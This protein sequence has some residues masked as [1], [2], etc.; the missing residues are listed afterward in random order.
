M[1][2]K[3][4]SDKFTHGS[5]QGIESNEGGMYLAICADGEDRYSRVWVSHEMQMQIVKHITEK[6]SNK[7]F[8]LAWLKNGGPVPTTEM[9]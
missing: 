3:Q 5:V 1:P 9:E 4:R 7:A 6:L 8:Q 2:I